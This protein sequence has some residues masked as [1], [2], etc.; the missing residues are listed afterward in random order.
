MEI[1]LPSPQKPQSTL[2]SIH[3][4]SATKRKKFAISQQLKYTKQQG[5]SEYL[6]ALLVEVPSYLNSNLLPFLIDI[7]QWISTH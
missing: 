4:S 1:T 6:V 3:P 2:W 7:Q 5:K